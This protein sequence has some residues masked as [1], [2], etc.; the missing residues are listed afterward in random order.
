MTTAAPPPA[1]LD[2]RRN[3]GR[4]AEDEGTEIEEQQQ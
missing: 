3:L 4:G 1:Y 2:A